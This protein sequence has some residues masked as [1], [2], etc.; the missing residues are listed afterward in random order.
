MSGV[1]M[2][3]LRNTDVKKHLAR[4][5]P[6]FVAQEKESDSTFLV[7]PKAKEGGD[8]PVTAEVPVKP[9]TK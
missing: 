8:V 4:S 5:V 1:P 6:R 2:S 7:S 3:F 9:E